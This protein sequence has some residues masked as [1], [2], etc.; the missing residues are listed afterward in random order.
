MVNYYPHTVMLGTNLLKSCFRFNIC[1]QCKLQ[2][3]SY[4]NILLLY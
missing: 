1:E 4:I 2:K 3:Y